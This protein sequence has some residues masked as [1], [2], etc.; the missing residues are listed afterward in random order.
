MKHARAVGEQR[1][2]AFA[3]IQTPRV[4]LSERGDEV[5][6][7]LPFLRGEAHHFGDYRVVRQLRE[8]QI[9]LRHASCIASQFLQPEDGRCREIRWP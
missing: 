3:K 8:R 2:A 5:R 6:G 4:E 9:V 7:G 1:R